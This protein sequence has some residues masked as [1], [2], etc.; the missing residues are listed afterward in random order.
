MKHYVLG[1]THRL[2]IQFFRYLFVGGSASVVDLIV[3]S[4]LVRQISMHYA[5]AAVIGYTAGFLWNH[6]LCL[7]WIFETRHG[8]WKDF[9]LAFFITLGGL[10][11]TELLLWIF[12]DR[13]LWDALIAKFITLWIVL[14][15]NFFLRKYFVFRIPAA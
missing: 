3:F 9:S 4:L 12:I 15:W 7:L 11:W 2:H 6:A 8:V 13:M 1:R 10:F 5:S 14:L